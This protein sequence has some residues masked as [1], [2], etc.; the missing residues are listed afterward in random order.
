MRKH[1][2]KHEIKELE[3]S[4][5]EFNIAYT[6]KDEIVME[7]EVIFINKKPVLF[8]YEKR[9]VPTIKSIFLG[10]KLKTITVDMGAV[11]F[12]VSGADIMRP[13]ITAFDEGIK[14]N[15]LVAVVDVNNKKPLAIGI[16]LM[17]SE[18][19]QNTKI[20]KAVKNIHYI[21][22]EVWKTE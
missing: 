11:R 2:S 18:I 16:A 3:H 9:I 1:L 12:V 5:A 15:D 20:G 10:A 6:K 13:G 17:D 14:E 22:D 21:G 8:Y 4:F 7:N 19:L